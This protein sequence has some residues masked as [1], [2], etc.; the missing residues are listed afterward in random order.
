MRSRILAARLAGAV[1][2]ISLSPLPVLAQ[3]KPG[4][5]RL[6]VL[7]CGLAHAPDMSRWTTGVNIGKPVDVSDNCYLIKHAQG[8]MIWDTGIADAV[9]DMPNGLPSNPPGGPTWTRTKKLSTQLE[10]LG[11]KPADIKFVAVSH[12]HGDH[13]GNVEMFPQAM[14]LVQQTEYEWPNPDKSPRFKP[15]HPV[16]KLNGDHDVFGDGT[17]TI[18]STPGHTPG[19]QSLMVKLPATGVVILSGDVVHLKENW[20]AKRAPVFNTSQEQSAASM[21]KVADLMA[22]NSAQLWINHDLPQTLTIRHAPE[23]YE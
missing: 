23:L 10:A 22:K 5:E 21:Q 16:T 17:V 14:L 6:Y 2:V 4:V 9:A 3:T 13:I 7:D 20:D 8:F 15:E 11:V 18:L 12:T 19:H 1:C